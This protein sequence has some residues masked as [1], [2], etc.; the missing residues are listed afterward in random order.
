[1]VPPTSIP[2]R[3]LAPIMLSSLQD[4]HTWRRIPS[5]RTRARRTFRYQSHL[6]PLY[7]NHTLSAI[8]RKLTCFE[9]PEDSTFGGTAS[10]TGRREPV[11]S[12][13]CRP[14]ASGTAH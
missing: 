9:Q 10:V 5:P 6:F 7:F 4:G 11:L 14:R 13:A 1:K 12:P 2:S 3:K 8:E